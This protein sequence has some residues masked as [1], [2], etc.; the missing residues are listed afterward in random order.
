MGTKDLSLRRVIALESNVNKLIVSEKVKVRRSE[1]RSRVNSTNI[2]E[3]KSGVKTVGV[4]EGSVKG[5]EGL[6]EVSN[7]APVLMIR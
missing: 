6:S 5:R 3:I 7:T 1:L 2:G 4:K